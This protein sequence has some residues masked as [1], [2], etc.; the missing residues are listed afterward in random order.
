LFWLKFSVGLV[1]TIGTLALAL[2]PLAAIVFGIRAANDNLPTVFEEAPQLIGVGIAV[3]VGT[4]CAAVTAMAVLRQAVYAAIAALAAV[5]AIAVLLSTAQPALQVG[6]L[7]S[8][9]STL[10]LLTTI[11]AWVAV[12]KD[13]GW[14][15]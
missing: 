14:K 13:W 9:M 7:A 6:A 3:Q 12:R 1:L 8:I 15:H 10:L 2:A 4:Y 11:V 5:I